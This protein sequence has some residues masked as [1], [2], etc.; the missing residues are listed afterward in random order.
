MTKLK[1]Q[2]EVAVKKPS[3]GLIQTVG[4]E[5]TVLVTVTVESHSRSA[6]QGIFT[7][8]ADF[9]DKVSPG[10]GDSK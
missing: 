10:A 5:E 1:F 9:T 6:A 7:S 3:S 2:K 8:V 4:G